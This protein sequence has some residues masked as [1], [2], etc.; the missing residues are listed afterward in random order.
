MKNRRSYGSKIILFFCAFML[1]FRIN[2]INTEASEAGSKVVRVGWYQSDMF[3]EGM[4]DEEEKSG[5]CYDYLQKVAD[6][7]EWQYEY[8]YGDWTE[9]YQKLLNGEIDFLGGVSWT[10]ERQYRM[11]FPD[12]EMGVDHYYIY[13]HSDDT[14]I[15]AD[16][17]TT[18]S[19]KKIG[20]ITNNQ[21]TTLIQQ[22][23]SENDIDMEMVYFGSFDEQ[24]IAFQKGE[25]DLF[26]QTI[27]NSVGID[28]IASVVNIGK[29][30]FYMAVSRSRKDL[31]RE[32]NAA[33]S[34]MTSTSPFIL[35]KM[36]D[37]NY[38]ARLANSTM[39]DTEKAWLF[40]HSVLK[41]GYLDDYLPYSDQDEDG[42]AKGLMTDVLKAILEALEISDSVSLQY[43]CYSKYKEMITAL[44]EGAIDIAFPVYG[45]LWNLE[46]DGI[47]A[48]SAVL[49]GS[50]SL[51]YKGTYDKA[52]IQRIA[53]NKNNGMQIAYSNKM[54]PDARLVPCSSIEDCLNSVLSGESEGT[55]INTLRT[56]L[57]TDNAKYSSLSSVQLPVQ[58]ERCFGV[59]DLNTE[60]LLILNKGLALLGDSYGI[61]NS[62]KYMGGLTQYTT[63]DFVRDHVKELGITAAVFGGLAF[64]TLV[65]ALLKRGKYT[66]RLTEEV[67]R[68]TKHIYDIQNSVV[69]GLANM[70]ENRDDNT[71]G[72]VK[73]TSD[74]I[75]FLVEELQKQGIYRVDDQKALD[76]VRAASTHDLGKISID[77]AILCKPARLS[78]DEYEVMKTHAPKSGEIVQIILDGVEEQHFVDVSYN[79]ARYHHERWDGKGYP[80]GLKRREIPIE[81]RIMAIAD[82]Y[83]A[84]VSKRCYK[85]PM[86]FEE[87]FKIM[88]DNMGTQFDPS[89]KSVVIAC[90]EKMEAYYTQNA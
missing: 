50:E 7:T 43:E 71:G 24:K 49:S 73:R 70:V 89:L 36:Q 45:N 78:P 17:L 77:S 65:I 63:M 16:D 76:I 28:D 11:H 14:S 26:G 37:E 48:T 80:D 74:V 66:T 46:Q 54:F 18:L 1:L 85:E 52:N 72:H 6:Y 20:A 5:Y 4:S 57:V 84:L 3:Q 41:V 13:K 12:E 27:Y 59:D 21:I 90:R 60:L 40:D 35:Q 38:G 44:N 68:Q 82:V 8:V 34:T 10:Q 30:S 64:L 19:G 61:E 88:M 2:S 32:L 51:F 87:A 55:I 53:V 15:T 79:I 22:W 86:S 23:M 62:Y 47:D 83:D 9:L 75:G 42:I 39:S 67:N 69:L 81:A 29:E 31:V 58:E 56:T 33:V 25:I